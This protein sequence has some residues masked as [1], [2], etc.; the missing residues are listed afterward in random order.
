MKT[1]LLCIFAF[2]ILLPCAF[3]SAQESVSNAILAKSDTPVSFVSWNSDGASFATTWNNSVILWDAESNTIASVFSGH[4]G[5]VRVVRFSQDG[6]WLLTLGD[7]NAVVVRDL[8]FSVS[9]TRI[10]G[11]GYLPVNDAVFAE[12]GNSIILPLDGI[13]IAH[14]YRLRLTQQFVTRAVVQ[15]VIPVQSLDITKDGSKLLVSGQDGVVTIYDVATGAVIGS[16]PRFSASHVPPR[17]SP[18]GKFFMAAASRNSLVIAPVTGG[19]A[20]TIRDTGLPVHSAE[21]NAD[22]T[23][24]AVALADGGIKIYDIQTGA[25]LQWYTVNAQGNNDVVN[26]LSFSPDGD[27]LIAGTQAGYIL[28]WSLTG[29]VFVPNRKQYLDKDIASIAQEQIEGGNESENE[30]PAHSEQ[31]QQTSGGGNKLEKPGNGIEIAFNVHTLN[32]NYYYA[33]FGVE[34]AYRNFSLYPL[35]W[36]TGLGLGAGIP[37][38]EYEFTSGYVNG[39]RL[40]DPW[41]YSADL[42]GCFG[43]CYYLPP[44]D[45][46]VF[47]EMRAGAN[48][49]IIYNNELVYYFVGDPNF[50]GSLDV[51]M[52]MQWKFLRASIGGEYD[53]NFGFL[54]KATL[55]GVIKLTGKKHPVPREE[56][57]VAQAAAADGETAATAAPQE[58]LSADE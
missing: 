37:N 28:R 7:D 51:L 29:K 26:A 30:V 38:G 18:D 27:Y 22:G 20:I 47:T 48:V 21:F 55:G 36:G 3:L 44:I 35:Y 10:M 49:K 23:R 41:L 6:K 25:Q 4:K 2:S 40:H 15:G 17:F 8:D 56:S 5:A 12:N 45:L 14:H 32:S 34:G 57:S 1:R 50:G 52:G 33:S 9:E 24:I 13:N 43:L 31:L 54:A 39:K 11:N 19:S 53:S 42:F 46:V 16:Y 58:T